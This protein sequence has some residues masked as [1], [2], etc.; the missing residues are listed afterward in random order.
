MFPAAHHRGGVERIAWEALRVLARRGPV[1]FVG[2]R[3]D[4]PID[5]VEHWPAHSGTGSLAPLRF[6]RSAGA[7]LRRR[8]PDDVVIAFGANCPV[9]DVAVVNSVHQVWLAHGRPARIKGIAVPN[10]VRYL[11]LRHQVLLAVERAYYRAMRTR[12]LVVVSEQVATD[13]AARFAVP[14]N[15]CTVL[16]NGFH[17]AQCSPDR[18]RAHRGEQRAAWGVADDE[19]V[20]LFVANELHRKGFDCLLDAVARVGDPRLSIRVVGR[21]PIEPYAARIDALGLT[22]RVHYHGSVDIGLAHAAADA[23]VLPTQYEAFA[24]TIVEALA[25]GLPVVTTTVPGA[26][27]LIAHGDNGLLQR[28][29][30]DAVELAGLLTRVLD[31][32]ERDR[33]SQAGPPS[34]AEL[35]WD[36]LMARLDDVAQA[37]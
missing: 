20:L 7:A 33:L 26:G 8:R 22:G 6:R 13:L 11:L 25:S 28:D 9:P 12:R 10:A 23:L 30:L 36:R 5:G 29:P 19:I 32:A 27:D 2:E 15:R 37:Q 14:R 35:S 16:H 17:P 4:P 18:R 3:L 1:V 24:L 34:V 31:P 21:A